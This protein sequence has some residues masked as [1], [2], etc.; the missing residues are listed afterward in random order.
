M[1]SDLRAAQAVAMT[2]SI[3]TDSQGKNKVLEENYS[4]RQTLTG[5]SA[6]LSTLKNEKL[7]LE[8]QN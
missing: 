5:Q 2:P 7:G 4:L 8:R 6:E 3:L 1:K